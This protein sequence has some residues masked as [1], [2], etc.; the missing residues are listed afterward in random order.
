MHL[1]FNGAVHPAG[2]TPASQHNP[3]AKQQAANHRVRAS[4]H[5]FRFNAQL[6]IAE[7][8]DGADR[9]PG[10]NRLCHHRA[11]GDPHIAKRGGKADLR[12]FNE[13]TKTHAEQHRQAEFG[14][15]H[16]SAKRPGDHSQ[17]DQHTEAE[18]ATRLVGFWVNGDAALTFVIF[19]GMRNSGSRVNLAP[20]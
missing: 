20:K 5:D 18:T 4:P 8:T 12:A 6:N 17:K 3:E 10:D 13:Q 15:I 1:T 2:F 19:T 14:L 16:R 9:H 11:A 7:D